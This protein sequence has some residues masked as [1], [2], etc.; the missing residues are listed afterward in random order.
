M[1][2]ALPGL[3]R[4]QC[5]G[6]RQCYHII[7]RGRCGVPPQCDTW[8]TLASYD[9]SRTIYVPPKWFDIPLQPRQPMKKSGRGQNYFGSR[10]EEVG[11]EIKEGQSSL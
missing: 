11:V 4:Y 7:L 2:R 10:S 6:L 5:R 8:E 1:R 3:S 9:E